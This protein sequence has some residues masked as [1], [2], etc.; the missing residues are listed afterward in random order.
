MKGAGEAGCSGAVAAISNAIM[1][2]LGDAASA[3]SGCGPFT[4]QAVHRILK[5]TRR[6]EAAA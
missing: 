5:R 6:R 2:A 1:N 4:P 3:S